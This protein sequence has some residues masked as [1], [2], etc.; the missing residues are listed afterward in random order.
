MYVRTE[1]IH[2][3]QINV[4]CWPRDFSLCFFTTVCYTK[5]PFLLKE[6][7]Q[8]TIDCSLRVFVNAYRKLIHTYVTR[9]YIFKSKEGKGR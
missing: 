9:F 2:S 6:N 7:K 1:T 3:T 4:Q 8:N 5:F